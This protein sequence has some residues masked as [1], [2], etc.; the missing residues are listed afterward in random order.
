MVRVSRI[1]YN[2]L[3]PDALQRCPDRCSLKIR[4][5]LPL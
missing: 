1:H 3:R 4:N 5:S 2:V